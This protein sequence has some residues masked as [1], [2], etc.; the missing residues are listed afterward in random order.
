MIRQKNIIASFWFF[1]ALITVKVCYQNTLEKSCDVSNLSNT[2]MACSDKRQEL[3][4]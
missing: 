4:F 3:P 2:Q 1:S